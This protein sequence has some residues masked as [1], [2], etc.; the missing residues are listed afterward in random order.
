MPFEVI[1][2]RRIRIDLI[3]K[4]NQDT[5]IDILVT[6]NQVYPRSAWIKELDTF[7][8]TRI[9]KG[10]TGITLETDFPVPDYLED[11]AKL[12]A[13]I[14]I[15]DFDKERKVW[16]KVYDE[17]IID[18]I[19]VKPYVGYEEVELVSVEIIRV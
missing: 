14:Q 11:N 7:K 19:T 16:K 4:S 13:V 15:G 2:G 5:G 6:F 10:E 9:S 1:K 17:A 12:Q 18:N 8:T 3:L